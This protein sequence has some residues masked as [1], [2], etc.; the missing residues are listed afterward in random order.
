[1][2]TI[3]HTELPATKC[4]VNRGKAIISRAKQHGIEL[5]LIITPMSCGGVRV[6]GARK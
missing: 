1:M 4:P 6:R 5:P 2:L 3:K